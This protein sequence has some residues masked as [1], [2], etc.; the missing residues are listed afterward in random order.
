MQAHQLVHLLNFLDL[1]WKDK[2]WALLHLI[3]E[4]KIFGEPA[5][6]MFDCMLNSK[7]FYGYSWKPE[8]EGIVYDSGRKEIVSMNG[9]G[10]RVMVP[11]R[12]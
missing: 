8:I 9:L 1:W 12:N 2:A 5:P 6:Y 11:R 10:W 3:V 7:A 4:G